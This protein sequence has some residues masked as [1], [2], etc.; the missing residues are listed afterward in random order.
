M[1]TNF[2][3]R[4]I[5]LAG[6]VLF[7]GACASTQHAA[8]ISKPVEPP[9]PSSS[10]QSLPALGN[11]D[12]R[13]RSELG[14]LQ[15]LPSDIANIVLSFPVAD[16]GL[17]AID[18]LAIV[19]QSKA[20]VLEIPRIGERPDRLINAFGPLGSELWVR[21]FESESPDVAGYLVQLS[22][23]CRLVLNTPNEV[24]LNNAR[25]QCEKMERSGFNTGLRAYRKANNLPIEDLTG[26]IVHPEETLGAEV[27]QQYEKATASSPFPDD[28]R[29]D[30]VPVIRWIVEADPDDPLPED[31][32]TFGY[33]SFAHAG[34]LLWNGDHF[35]TRTTVPAALWP[36]I[37]KTPQ[38]DSWA[39]PKDDR[40]VTGRKR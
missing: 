3:S 25:T 33:G 37:D 29:I 35:E 31:R 2:L 21:S 13:A 11:L 28:S 39:C 18:L 40:F 6:S 10:A 1:N 19:R 14:T 38:K 23:D 8:N 4:I 26:T 30:R 34:F 22:I 36:C 24:A 15:P 9:S 20:F 17:P 7:T 5:V 27:L 32:H 16:L 12:Y